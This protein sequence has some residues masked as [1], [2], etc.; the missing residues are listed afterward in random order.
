MSLLESASDALLAARAADGD[1]LAFGV[2]VRRHAPYLRAFAAR[3]LRSNSDADDIV[4]EALIV[5]WRRL[6][7]LDD[8]AA[9]RSW[10]TTIVSRKAVERAR[11]TKPTSDLD[12]IDL[13]AVGDDPETSALTSARMAALSA[14]LRT[15]PD[16]QRQIWLLREVAGYS[17]A[18]IADRLDTSVPTV[19]G[20][21]ARARGTVL[22][23]M[24]EWR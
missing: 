10:L 13:P 20:R 18:E 6:P 8:P 9:L 19:R 4:Q 22:E 3:M 23:Q 24:T 5:A 1:E 12:D 21:L 17:Y 2:I 15:L 14:I 7:D 16:D 11:S